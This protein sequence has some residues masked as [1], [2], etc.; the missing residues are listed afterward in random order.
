MKNYA[1]IL[2]MIFSVISTNLLGQSDFGKR[3]KIARETLSET[4]KPRY[5]DNPKDPFDPGGGGEGDP[6][7]INGGLLLLISGSMAYF[8]VNRKTYKKA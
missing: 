4:D 3:K 1:F 2:L 6:I 8:V 7:P 5:K